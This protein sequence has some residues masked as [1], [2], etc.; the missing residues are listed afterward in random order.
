M[1]ATD[2]QRRMGTIVVTVLL[3]AGLLAG[4]TLFGYL[5]YR[6]LSSRVLN[7]RARVTAPQ[8]PMVAATAGQIALATTVPSNT[9]HPPTP[10]PAATASLT[11]PP[12]ASPE[13]PAT[14]TVQ[15]TPVPDTPAP[16]ATAQPAEVAATA[17]EAPTA[18]PLPAPSAA[19]QAERLAQTGIGLWPPLLG[20]ALA[21]MVLGVRRLRRHG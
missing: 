16:T 10:T 18:T 11:L 2:E 5:G 12:T 3:A 9:P 17:T 14:A 4:L 21:G 13:P 20:L 7:P 1:T 8:N 6:I 19:P 15:P